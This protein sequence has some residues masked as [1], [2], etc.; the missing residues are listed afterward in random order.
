M[1][2]ND[3]AAKYGKP[4]LSDDGIKKL[5]DRWIAKAKEQ[6]E[7]TRMV[8]VVMCDPPYPASLVRDF[9]ENLI[10]TG[11]LRV[12]GE[13]ELTPNSYDCLLT[14]SGCKEGVPYYLAEEFAD[15]KYCPSCGSIIKPTQQP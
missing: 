5:V 1:N 9:Y 4:M 7:E 6:G 8:E 12:V 15:C 14:C 10:A 3:P 13:V 2:T 11:K